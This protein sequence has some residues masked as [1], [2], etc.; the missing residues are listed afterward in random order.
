MN[1]EYVCLGNVCDIVKGQQI[2]GEDLTD[3]G[4]YYVMNGGVEPS[5]YYNK[6][7]VKGDTVSISEGGNSCGYVQYNIEPFW[8]GGHC[9]TLQKLSNSLY[10]KY[11]YHILKANELNIMRLR[12]GSG[13]PNIQK[14]ELINY[15]ILL[16]EL[17]Q[18][19]VISK[20]LDIIEEK[21]KKETNILTLFHAQKKY[22][23]QH[24]FI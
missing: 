2:N 17:S 3:Y 6:A 4:N 21:L 19:K 14:K 13:L 10:G 15:A 18:Q 5:G 7:N 20:S 16:P 22:L 9:Y 24:L 11:L 12:I 1:A 23:L 8:S